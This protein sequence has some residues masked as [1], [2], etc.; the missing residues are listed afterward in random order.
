[1]FKEGRDISVENCFFNL[2]YPFWHDDRLKIKG[3]ETANKGSAK[4]S[5][6][7]TLTP[8][9]RIAASGVSIENISGAPGIN[10][11]KT[12]WTI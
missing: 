10:G 3:S 5:I 4:A 8:N 6:R 12:S 7:S 9:S 11:L 1:M 2:R